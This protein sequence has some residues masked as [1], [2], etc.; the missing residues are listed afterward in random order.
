M[1]PRSASPARGYS[2]EHSNYYGQSGGRSEFRINLFGCFQASDCGF[3]CCCAHSFCGPCVWSSA[4]NAV[5][6]K[7]SEA[8]AGA[9]VL[10]NVRGDGASFFQ[11]AAGLYAA[12]GGAKL[13]RKLVEKLFNRPVESG[14]FQRYCIHSC[15]ISCAMVQEVDAVMTYAAE[16]HGRPLRYNFPWCADLEF[17]NEGR[18]PFER[19]L[20][21][22]RNPDRSVAV[23][24]YISRP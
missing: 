20:D 9:R 1:Q 5:G 18:P 8:T 23:P 21:P 13:R 15:C 19:E 17:R 22:E 12:F 10:S 7:G 16:H 14:F 6:V 11:Q 3:A 4:M 24:L 2:I